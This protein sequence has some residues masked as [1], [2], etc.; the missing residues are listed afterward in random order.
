MV[1]TPLLDPP[2]RNET[3]LRVHSS[4]ILQGQG[5]P[6]CRA[7]S[8]IRRSS[9]GK[10]PLPHGSIDL[11]GRSIDPMGSDAPGRRRRGCKVVEHTPWVDY[12]TILEE[13]GRTGIRA[14]A[15]VP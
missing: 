7:F 15:R 4:T 3:Q 9:L 2:M 12:R 5:R 1:T 10:A 8:R 13:E 11:G 14:V 6:N